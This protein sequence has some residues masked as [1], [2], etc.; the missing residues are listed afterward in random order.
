MNAALAA[1][2]LKLRTTRTVTSLF[3]AMLGLVLLAVALHGFGL[4]DSARSESSSQRRVLIA[5]ETVGAV[6]AALLGAMSIT[7]E[8]R[9]GTIRLTLLGEPNR[10]TVITVKALTSAVVGLMFGLVATTAAVAVAIV[11]FANRDF[12]VQV[13]RGDD[14]QLVAGGAI[15]GALWAVIGLGIGSLVRNQVAATIGIFGWLQIIENLLIDSLPD[16]SRY[17]PGSLAQALAGSQIGRVGSATAALLLPTT[18]AAI[19][20][21]IGPARVV[22]RDVA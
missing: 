16:V 22:R 6:F 1:E 15:A 7:A 14:A 3:L 19:V 18:Y 20:L 10:R 13:D 8:M 21:L 17:T 12:S 5:G 9:H 4:P 2:I 11:A